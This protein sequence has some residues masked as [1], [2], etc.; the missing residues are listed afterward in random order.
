MADP[1]AVTSAIISEFYRY[2]DQLHALVNQTREHLQNGTVPQW[3][4]PDSFAPKAIAS[5]PTA[6]TSFEVVD[7]DDNNSL[8]YALDLVAAPLSSAEPNDVETSDSNT[9]VSYMPTEISNVE[10]VDGRD[11]ASSSVRDKSTLRE[12]GHERERRVEEVAPPPI[13]TEE[14]VPTL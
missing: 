12:S 9:A 6:D 3:N 8:A 2:Q 13:E 1:S 7:L 14:V 4:T 5:T 11:H 10:A